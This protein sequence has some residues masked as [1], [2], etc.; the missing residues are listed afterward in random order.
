MRKLIL[1]GATV[2]GATVLSASAIFSEV[3]GRKAITAT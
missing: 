2:I 3:V 1:I